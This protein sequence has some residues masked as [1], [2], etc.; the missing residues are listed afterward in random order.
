MKI[1]CPIDFSE[2]S[3]NAVHYAS[4]LFGLDENTEI[5][6]IYCIDVA[7][8]ASMFIK[9]DDL[10]RS[11]AEEDFDVLLE[12]ARKK[13][14]KITYKSKIISDDPKYY[15]PAY[16]EKNKVNFVVIGTTG[17]T[18]LKDIT[19]GSLTEALFEKCSAPVLA[20]PNKEVHIDLQRV[21]LALD[22]SDVCNDQLLDP[23]KK[24]LK[25]DDAMIHICHVKT[26]GDD[27]MEYDPNVNV[28]LSDFEYDYTLLEAEVSVAQAIHD[29]SEKVDADILVLIHNRRNWWEKLFKVSLTKEELY[30]INTPLLV[31]NR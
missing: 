18:Q 28:M 15:I 26:E 16:A 11:R 19:V 29:F 27:E 13:F 22:D 8:R 24:I 2:T 14:P 6:L 9:I 20:V 21:V 7:S 10:L 12:K 25:L 5:E 1:L 4:S 23:L 17:M 3:V 30:K 31:I